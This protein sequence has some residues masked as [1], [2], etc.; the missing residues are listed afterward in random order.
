[1]A[2]AV[3]PALYAAG[4]FAAATGASYAASKGLNYLSNKGIPKL[5]TKGKNYFTKKGVKKTKGGKRARKVARII[6][7]IEKGYNSKVGRY[8]RHGVVT[9]GSLGAGY[10]GGKA[11]S[12]A[13]NYAASTPTAQRFAKDNNLGRQLTGRGPKKTGFEKA[14]KKQDIKIRA[15]KA[16]AAAP[17]KAQIAREDAADAAM[18]E[19]PLPKSNRYAAK[20]INLK[21][22]QQANSR[23]GKGKFRL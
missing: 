9:A 14:I 4:Q 11:F 21:E 3:L 20:P 1:M 8:V 12:S 23:S 16:A 10:A 18:Y 2:V 22:F 17:A 6:G 19:Q 7:K 15:E 13:A 5:I